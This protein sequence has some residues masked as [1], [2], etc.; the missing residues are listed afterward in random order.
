M[1]YISKRKNREG[2]TYVYLVEGYRKK[3]KVKTRILKSYG[4][5]EKMEA[6]EPGIFER[7]RQEARDG[8]IG[9][10]EIEEL[11]VSYRLDEEIKFDDVNYGWKLFDELY[12]ELDLKKV[13]VSATKKSKVEFNVNTILRLLAFQRILN[14][15]SKLATVASQAELF[16]EWNIDEN[17]MYR[18]L[19]HINQMKNEIQL[20]TH[21]VIT[22]KIGRAA[23]LVFYDV[24]NYY[25]EINVNRLANKAIQ[26]TN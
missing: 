9:K 22:E 20:K 18:S 16:G 7:L 13:V 8:I 17:S 23:T 24:T 1:A 26:W 10:K 19:T 14:P 25:F 6:K 15:G 2:K 11:K 4:Q 3:N 5:L 21:Q 12:K